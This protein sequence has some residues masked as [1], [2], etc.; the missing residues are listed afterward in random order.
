[1]LLVSGLTIL[2]PGARKG[3]NVPRQDRSHHPIDDTTTRAGVMVAPTCVYIASRYWLAELKT[4]H[5]TNMARPFGSR[6]EAL[7]GLTG[8]AQ[9]D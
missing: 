8:R 6:A 2:T 4:L 3:P 9:S 1:V 7:R 5:G